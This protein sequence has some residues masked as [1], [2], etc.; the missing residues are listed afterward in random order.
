MTEWCF[1]SSYKLN[2]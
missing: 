2:H 1:A